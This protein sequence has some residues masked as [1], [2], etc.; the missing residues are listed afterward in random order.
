[1]KLEKL[2]ESNSSVDTAARESLACEAW[3]VCYAPSGVGN[4][5]RR[6]FDDRSAC[7][8]AASE[9][10]DTAPSAEEI[11]AKVKDLGDDNFDLREAASRFFE[12]HA[13]ELLFVKDSLTSRDPEVA[14]RARRIVQHHANKFYDPQFP[15]DLSKIPVGNLQPVADFI[16]RTADFRE[17]KK[18]LADIIECLKTPKAKF[19]SAWSTDVTANLSA[20]LAALS[21]RD[22]KAFAK[23]NVDGP[24]QGSRQ[25]ESKFLEPLG[26]LTQLEELSFEMNVNLGDDALKELEPLKN[27]RKLSVFNSRFT[28]KGVM[29]F[30]ALP[31]LEVL[32]LGQTSINDKGLETLGGC[33]KLK[34]LNL[35]YAPIS[36][37]GVQ[38]LSR[39][40]MLERLGLA[41]TANVGDKS[42]EAL[43]SLTN[44]KSLELH[45][46]KV[47]D[48]G[49][50]V[51]KNFPN[52][53]SINLWGAKVSDS[54]LAHMSGLKNMQSFACNSNGITDE[55]LKTI[56]TFSELRI[57]ELEE[58]KITSNGL[59]ALKTLK[60]LTRLNLGG[61]SI[62]DSD[63]KCLSQLP[64]AELGLQGTRLTDACVDELAGMTNLKKL[65]VIGSNL[66][67]D[68]VMKLR[69]AL[70]GCSVH[71][72][73]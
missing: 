68:A 61:S 21:Q 50:K 65:N 58:C 6:T 25:V 16:Q 66:T 47:T 59:N 23:M 49:M 67:R 18:Q 63:V 22:G 9:S 41:C 32:D 72:A 38:H 30:V 40:T 11:A 7:F 8:D 5:E 17:A 4:R 42:L 10:A 43:K 34:E 55:G 51:L 64:I 3:M 24:Y 44:I 29:S 36:D 62:T 48:V 69:K 71:G 33:T 14:W 54:G 60:K 20:Q 73:D 57:L 12:G 37:A 26:K 2:E 56:A 39:L 13:S 28:E 27:L 53:E 70:P 52:L 31:K 46:C 35:S 15:K 1:M 19:E 45:H